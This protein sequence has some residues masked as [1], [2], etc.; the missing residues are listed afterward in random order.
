MKRRLVFLLVSLLMVLCFLPATALAEDASPLNGTAFFDWATLGTFAGAVAA[1]VFITQLLK[2]PLDKVWR[3]P[4]QMVVYALSLA[5]LLIGQLAQ[6]GFAWDQLALCV[7]NAAVVALMAMK[8]YEIAI[9]RVEESK[10]IKQM[11]SLEGVVVPEDFD[12]ALG[13]TDTQAE[14]QKQDGAN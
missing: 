7:L 4:T 10:L 3:I 2:L 13:K 11:T 14:T 1:V 12:K 8:S 6:G 5:V 9:G